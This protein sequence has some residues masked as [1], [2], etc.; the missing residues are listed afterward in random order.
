MLLVYETTKQQYM[1]LYDTTRKCFIHFTNAIKYGNT[2]SEHTKIKFPSPIFAAAQISLFIFFILRNHEPRSAVFFTRFFSLFLI[3]FLFG[4]KEKSITNQK[5]QRK[6]VL[7][8][9]REEELYDLYLPL[10]PSSPEYVP[11]S[12]FACYPYPPPPPRKR[13]RFS[14]SVDADEEK[15]AGCLM[16]QNEEADRLAVEQSQNPDILLLSF[17]QSEL[18]EEIFYSPVTFTNNPTPSSSSLSSSLTPLPPKKEDFVAWTTTT[19]TTTA[20]GS[21]GCSSSTSST[22]SSSPSSSL[23]SN[24]DMTAAVDN[25]AE[26]CRTLIARM[27]SC[28]GFDSVGRAFKIDKLVQTRLAFSSEVFYFFFLSFYLTG[29]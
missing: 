26:R 6:G 19:T 11:A 22:T 25:V 16:R 14:D 3:F 18:L 2:F 13:V 23:S 5:Q 28:S 4:I 8:R 29:D 17:D 27:A 1:I 20:S 10:A 12:G 21:S 24:R 9:P 7:K 15:R